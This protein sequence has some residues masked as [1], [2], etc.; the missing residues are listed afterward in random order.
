VSKENRVNGTE[1]AITFPRTEVSVKS[2]IERI[3]GSQTIMSNLTHFGFVQE[4]HADGGHHLHGYLLYRRK[5]RFSFAH[6]DALVADGEHSVGK[7]GN[8][9]R[10]RNRQAWLRYMLKDVDRPCEPENK[11]TFVMYTISK[12]F[13][14]W[15]VLSEIS[16]EAYMG[17]KKSAGQ[18]A[19]L[20][21]ML[22]ENPAVSMAEIES[23]LESPFFGQSFRKIMEITAYKKA[24]ALM[25]FVMPDG[26]PFN[27]L[28]AGSPA[29]VYIAELCNK[30]VAAVRDN[31]QIEPAPKEN[32]IVLYGPPGVHK[33]GFHRHLSKWLP[34]VVI[35]MN[36]TF[37]FNGV[38][39]D[40][41]A[42]VVVLE[43]FNGSPDGLTYS[44]FQTMIDA[45]RNQVFNAKG[46]SLRL[47]YRPL[48][49]ICSNTPPAH[50]W[51]RVLATGD[52]RTHGTVRT[53]LIP[54]EREAL[55]VRL[56]WSV[57]VTT[58][59]MGFPDPDHDSNT[60]QSGIARIKQ[61]E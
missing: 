50:W 25:N 29:M 11:P 36:R 44:E 38:T 24:Q 4:E 30:L 53:D 10:V 42:R 18:W 14:D 33:S 57:N 46:A 47:R 23:K 31:A 60:F 2:V 59:I 12:Q 34:T 35:Q 48:F 58:P 56:T 19:L 20:L 45:D 27:A 26:L 22:R 51:T 61:F 40:C 21:Q 15:N 16:Q 39:N 55:E 9:Q 7:R 13:Q 5:V 1:F 17:G 3:K 32:V 8:Y 6:W 28:M 54:E 37:F 52:G 41:A 43:Q 49:I